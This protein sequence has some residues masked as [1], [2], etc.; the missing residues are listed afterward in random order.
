MKTLRVDDEENGFF[1]DPGKR[2]FLPLPLSDDRRCLPVK[3][4]ALR[5]DILRNPLYVGVGVGT[6]VGMGVEGRGGVVIVVGVS[7]W[8]DG[9]GSG[10]LAVTEGV[11]GEGAAGGETVPVT[12]GGTGTTILTA[13]MKGN[14]AAAVAGAGTGGDPAGPS[15]VAGVG[16]GTAVPGAN[17]PEIFCSNPGVVTVPSVPG[18]AGTGSSVPCIPA[19][20]LPIPASDGGTSGGF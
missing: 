4:R 13:G 18:D 10:G 6:V 5:G 15:R 1:R 17:V 2:F 20:S 14:G 19:D 11:P 16:T 12:E 9:A 8:G 7:V 3:Q